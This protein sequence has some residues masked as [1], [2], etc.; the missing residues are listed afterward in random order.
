MDS[1]KKKRNEYYVKEKDI[2]EV[3]KVFLK[4]HNSLKSGSIS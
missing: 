3:D 4:G 2:Y 1:G